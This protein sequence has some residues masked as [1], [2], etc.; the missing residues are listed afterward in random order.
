MQTSKNYQSG[1]DPLAFIKRVAEA[2]ASRG[3]IEDY[4]KTVAPDG[5]RTGAD[6]RFKDGSTRVVNI[7]TGKGVNFNTRSGGTGDVVS[8]CAAVQGVGQL[9]AA[10]RLNDRYSLGIDG[11]GAPSAHGP[12][13]YTRAAGA[14]GVVVHAANRLKNEGEGDDVCTDISEA[15]LASGV[16]TWTPYKNWAGFAFVR[17]WTYRHDDGRA[18]FVVARYEK[19]GEKIFHPWC[20]VGERREWRSKHFPKP[21][22]IYNLPSLVNNPDAVV[23]VVEGE[24]CASA[25]ES[26]KL[27][28]VVF[29]TWA[30]GASKEKNTHIEKA[31]WTPLAGRR[32]IVWADLDTAG[33]AAK[34]TILGIL[35]KV[36]AAEVF[37][38]ES[39]EKSAKWDIAEAVE[40][41]EDIEGIL[42]GA[43]IHR[44]KPT[45]QDEFSNAAEKVVELFPSPWTDFPTPHAFPNPGTV[46][47]SFPV[48]DLGALSLLSGASKSR[49]SWVATEL[50]I[51]AASGGDFQG[52]SCEKRRKVLY[53]DLELRSHFLAKRMHSVCRAKN[54]EPSSLNGFLMTLP[55]RHQHIDHSTGEIISEVTRIAREWGAEYIIIDPL[56]ILMDGD[57]SDPEVVQAVYKE[58]AKLT[59]D[60]G[61]GVLMLHHF[62]KGSSEGKSQIDLASGSGILARMPEAVLTIS[63]VHESHEIEDAYVFEATVRDHAPVKP[64]TTAWRDGLLR[65][66]N[67]EGLPEDQRELKRQRPENKKSERTPRP[68]QTERLNQTPAPIVERTHRPIALTVCK[69]PPPDPTPDDGRVEKNLSGGTVLANIKHKADPIVEWAKAEGRFERIDRKTKFGNPFETGKD[70]TQQEVVEKFAAWIQGQPE[71]IQQ[72]REELKGKVLGCWCYPELCH[73]DVLAALVDDQS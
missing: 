15:E 46:I 32:V 13:A 61:A 69:P 43:V 34:K 60:T 28:G 10:K 25:G 66:M 55:W 65:P 73:G 27:P 35:R 20:V 30:G 68:K 39:P 50:A 62:T 8:V 23:V 45:E 33:Q 21:R 67:S 4:C 44:T 52:F 17:S 26:L 1:G 16:S 5:K 11:D 72:A 58:C 7:K 59:R 42:E 31:E 64:F 56:Y 48:F 49:K 14:S 71:L 6:F 51:A 47:P 24:K 57:E 19:E 29:T 22:P 37:T 70:G 54:V 41:G 9:E 63:K 18:A 36:G 12:K 2:M 40:A 53:V 3:L 38:I